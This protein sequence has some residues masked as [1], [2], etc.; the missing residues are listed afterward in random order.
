MKTITVP[1]VLIMSAALISLAACGANAAPSTVPGHTKLGPAT[2][3]RQASGSAT[4][5]GGGP[6]TPGPATPKPAT[7]RPSAPAR[8]AAPAK[9]PTYG[10]GTYVVGRDI[11]PGTYVT[12]VPA[13]SKSCFWERDRT[14]ASTPSALIDNDSLYA[15]AHGLVVI[16]PTDKAFGTA[17]CGAWRPASNPATPA[18]KIGEGTFRVGIDVKPGRYTT[19]VPKDSLGCYWERTRSYN[20]GDPNATIAKA[21]GVPPGTKV[22][23]DLAAADK[24]F[25][26]N[27]C[28]TLT[29]R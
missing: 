10:D 15:G 2:T 27:S 29:Q 24:L 5:G 13:T 16:A 25:K 9:V 26:T 6:A 11:K 14:L 22:T 19:T 23:V 20:G 18:T 8:P 17:G 3:G 12:T 1:R 7:P 28:G 21:D 4:A